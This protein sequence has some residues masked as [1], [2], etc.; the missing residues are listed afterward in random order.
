MKVLFG[1]AFGLG[2]KSAD[3]SKPSADADNAHGIH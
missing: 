3:L 1:P 2:W